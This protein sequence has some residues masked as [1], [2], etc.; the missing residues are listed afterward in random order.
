MNEKNNE[1]SFTERSRLFDLVLNYREGVVSGNITG[2]G[3]SQEDE[4]DE[5]AKL[6][7]KLKD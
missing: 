6:L 4:L 2:Y 5:V 3:Q 1:L 7:A